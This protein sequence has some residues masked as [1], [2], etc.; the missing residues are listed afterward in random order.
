MWEID[1]LDQNAAVAAGREFCGYVKEDIRSPLIGHADRSSDHGTSSPAVAADFFLPILKRREFLP[2][3]Q[4]TIAALA[5]VRP[6]IGRLSC[7]AAP[8]SVLAARI[9]RPS[10]T[11][12]S[13]R[14]V[15][16]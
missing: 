1:E 11:P 12:F 3:V 4:A 5:F 14:S 16:I 8:T 7:Y 10:T 6:Q 2:E 9:P 15:R 13:D